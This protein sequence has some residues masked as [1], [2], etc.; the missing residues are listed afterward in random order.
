MHGIHITMK[1]HTFGW[2]IFKGM[3]KL[4]SV[5][6]QDVFVKLSN[7]HVDNLHSLSLN[8][9]LK[10]KWGEVIRSMDRGIVVCDTIMKY[11]FSL[12]CTS[13]SRI[14]LVCII[15]TI[16]FQYFKVAVKV[17]F[18]CLHAWFWL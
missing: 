9:H 8:W 11:A 3:S 4:C 7:A 1:Y 5:E 18:E 15:V 17:L 12:A 14:V 6:S 13:T 16:C 10:M 2:K